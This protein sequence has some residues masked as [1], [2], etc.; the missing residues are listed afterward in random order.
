MNRSILKTVSMQ[1]SIHLLPVIGKSL[2]A[3]LQWIMPNNQTMQKIGCLI[4]IC[5]Y[6]REKNV[7]QNVNV[8][9][10][11]ESHVASPLDNIDTKTA[12]TSLEKLDSDFEAFRKKAMLKEQEVMRKLQD[13]LN[14]NS[15]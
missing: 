11:G 15:H 1:V 13:E 7:E 12:H 9:L 3:L 14:K 4:V 6:D 5:L 8:F 2:T 10:Q